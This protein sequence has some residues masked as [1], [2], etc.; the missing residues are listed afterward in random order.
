MDEPHK[1]EDWLREQ[2]VEQGKSMDQIGREQDV[3]SGTIW[4][5]IDKHDIE[6]RDRMEAVKDA[7]R[8]NRANYHTMPSG[9]TRWQAS[10]DGDDEVMY[11]HR[12]LAISKYGVEAVMNKDIHHKNGIPWDNRPKNIDLL[13]PSEHISHHTHG[14]DSWEKKRTPWRDKDTLK[15]LYVERQMSCM[16]IADEFDISSTTVT[17]WLRKHDINVRPAHIQREL[18]G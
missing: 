5:Y 6:R 11:V 10:F 16:E 3:N 9:H 17:R 18:D 7:V 4:Y 15:E 12:L 1:D 14:R 2:Y 8:V 13:S